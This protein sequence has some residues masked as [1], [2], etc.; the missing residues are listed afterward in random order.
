MPVDAIL[1]WADYHDEPVSRLALP[2]AVGSDYNAFLRHYARLHGVEPPDLPDTITATAAAF[3][4][5]GRWLYQCGGCLA[6]V[7]VADAA[8]PTIC[9]SCGGGGWANVVFPDDRPQIEAELLRQPGHRYFAPVRHWRPGWTLA[10]LEVRTARANSL[11]ASNP[12]QM[13]RALSIG[14]PRTWTVGENLSATNMNIYISSILSDLSG[15][16]GVVEFR[17]S[18]Q[19]DSIIMPGGTTAQR[20]ADAAGRLRWNSTDGTLDLGTGSGWI[21][22]LNS[23]AV[24]FANLNANSA[25]GGGA[26]Q[27]AAGD[28]GHTPNTRQILAQRKGASGQELVT[29]ADW[30]DIYSFTLPANAAASVTLFWNQLNYEAY[31]AYVRL[32]RDGASLNSAVFDL[33]VAS[34]SQDREF[35]VLNWVVTIAGTYR[36]QSYAQSGRSTRQRENGI[37][38]LVQEFSVS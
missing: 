7:P 32:R 37:G 2:R 18:I 35:S 20:P 21:Q 13:V 16:N 3:V 12:G 11:L 33:G 26:N 24:T 10:D 28:H 31:L 30:R 9:V 4:D 8:T 38:L 29:A 17:N 19:A 1:T 15:D 5:A 27:V 36:L 22:M 14:L 6:A 34:G 23:G 25:V